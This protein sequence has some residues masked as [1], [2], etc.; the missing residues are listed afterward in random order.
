MLIRWPFAEQ[1]SPW[2]YDGPQLIRSC[3]QKNY[4]CQPSGRNTSCCLDEE[5]FQL[6]EVRVQTVIPLHT[7]TSSSSSSSSTSAAASTPSSAPQRATASASSSA[8][9][10]PTPTPEASSGSNSTN[11]GLAAGL[12]LVLG[13]AILGAVLFALYKWDQK[14]RMKAKGQIH[15]LDSPHR[16]SQPTPPVETNGYQEWEMASEANTHEAPV[17]GYV[18]PEYQQQRGYGF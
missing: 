15:M 2:N 16:S 1:N 13:L 12:G 18:H 14:R 8:S 7:S 6:P 11:K 10:S 9:S 17:R 4:C 5:F 3:G